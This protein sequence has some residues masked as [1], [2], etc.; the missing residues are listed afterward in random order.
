MTSP[1]IYPI[2]LNEHQIQ[3]IQD[4]LLDYS[5]HPDIIED[6]LNAISVSVEREDERSCANAS[7][8]L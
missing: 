6:V 1:R 5:T 8:E 7:E 2:Y 3:L 4:A